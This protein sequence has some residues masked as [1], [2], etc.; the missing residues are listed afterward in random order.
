MRIVN[1]TDGAQ[2]ETTP[3]IGSIVASALKTYANDAAYE[4]AELN[5]PALG[6]IYA[7]ETDNTI[8]YYNGSTWQ[9]VIDENTVQSVENKSIDADT[10]MITNIDN[11]EIK[12]LAGIEATKIADGSVDDTE[13]QHLD[14]VTSSIQTQ[15]DDKIPN[16]EKGAANGVAELDGSGLVPAAQLPSYVDDVEEYAD[17]ASFPATGESGKIYVALDTNFIYRWTGATYVDIT[18]KVDSVNGQTGV[19]SLGMNDIDDVNVGTPG[20]ADDG[21]VVGW[22]DA[23]S[24]FQLIPGGGSP[25]GAL[26]SR[27]VF[28]ASG[29]WTK[30]AGVNTALVEVIGGGGS[31]GAGAS[32]AAGQMSCASGGGGGGYSRSLIDVSGTSSETVTIGAGGTGSAG[33][34]GNTGGTSSFG[35]FLSATGGNGGIRSTASSGGRIGQGV[36]GGTGAGGEENSRGGGSDSAT[37]DGSTAVGTA[38]GNSNFGGGGSGRA[39]VLGSGSITGLAGGNY[40]GGG[41]GTCNGQSTTSTAGGAGASGIVVIWEFS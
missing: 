39:A 15:L 22:V 27:Q 11:N 7:N 16:A 8:R 41:S 28:T 10:N 18:G 3:T 38:G 24:E 6:N 5:A 19:V 34:N 4:A 36:S 13:F 30:P 21:K 35:A 17:L 1:F 32:T 31:G 33:N 40:G 23:S 14:G 37:S 26:L 2:S 20:P 25:S 29:T 12:P 9:E